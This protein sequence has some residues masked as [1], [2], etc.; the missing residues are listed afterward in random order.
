MATAALKL[1]GLVAPVF[2]PM[3]ADGSLD[4]DRVEALAEY[5]WVQGVAGVFVAGTTGEGLS[6]SVPERQ[7]LT[8]RWCAVA[9]G[10]FPVIAH[11]GHLSLPDA[12]ELASHAQR[13]GAT[14]IAAVPPFY[15]ETRPPCKV[16]DVV[17]CCVEIAAAAPGLPFYYYHIPAMTHVAMNVTEFMVAASVRL[18]TLAGLK[19]SDPDLIAFARTVDLSRGDYDLFFGVDELLLP[20]WS[21]GATAAIGSTYNFAAPLYRQMIEAL[22]RGDAQ[23]ARAFNRQVRDLAWCFR[24]HGGIPAMKATMRLKGLDCGPCRLPLRT[25]ADAERENLA[26]CLQDLLPITLPE[27]SPAP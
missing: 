3:H 18:P 5:M 4:L 22:E 8:E 10:Q 1:R 12:K 20:A 11:V 13:A 25:L 9:A 17:S 2:T 16:Q 15:Y 26:S 14:A 27:E 23:A 6:L 7:Q 24:V 21:V 19:F